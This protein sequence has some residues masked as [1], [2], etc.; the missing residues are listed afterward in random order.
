MTLK[1]IVPPL[2]QSNGTHKEPSEIIDLQAALEWVYKHP[3][4][5]EFP[6]SLSLKMTPSLKPELKKDQV[7]E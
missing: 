6:Q 3:R 2:S 4:Y 1:A 7:K 5:F